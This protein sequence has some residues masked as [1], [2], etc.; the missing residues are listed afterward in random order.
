MTNM[1][2]IEVDTLV[3][4]DWDEHLDDWQPVGE[5]IVQARTIK[6]VDDLGFV[7][8]RLLT[9]ANRRFVVVHASRLS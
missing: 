1:T 8:I 9:P 7:E 5:R 3:G 2:H 4:F 6:L